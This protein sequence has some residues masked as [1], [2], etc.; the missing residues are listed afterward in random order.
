M[1]NFKIDRIDFETMNPKFKDCKKALNELNVQVE[2]L[3]LIEKNPE[4]FISSYF[5][6]II[7]QVDLK[8]ELLK[9]AIDDY[10]LKTIEQIKKVQKE[11]PMT[12]ANIKEIS[13]EFGAIITS[14]NLLNNQL[15]SFDI[16]DVKID[17]MIRQVTELKIKSNSELDEFK[18]SLLSNKSFEF[19]E[20]NLK[21]EEIFGNFTKKEVLFTDIF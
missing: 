15:K 1:L 3:K 10:S 2:E 16:N 5:D 11:F 7:N 20:S 8:R 13:I 14:L 4:R 18:N 12:E 17:E 9:E 19:K 21:I 6:E